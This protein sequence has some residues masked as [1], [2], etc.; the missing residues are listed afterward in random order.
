MDLNVG[1]IS[2]D[3]LTKKMSPDK[4]KKKQGLNVFACLGLPSDSSAIGI[5]EP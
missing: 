1:L 5:E 3:R 2:M 4:K